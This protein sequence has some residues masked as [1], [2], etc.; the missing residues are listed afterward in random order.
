MVGPLAVE[1]AGSWDLMKAA[2]SAV[3]MAWMRAAL[4][5]DS[6]A[7][8]RADSKDEMTAAWSEAS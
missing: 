5:V 1:T 4:R 6:T 3:L 7:A 8:P 2:W